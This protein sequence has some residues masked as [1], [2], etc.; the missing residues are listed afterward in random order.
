MLQHLDQVFRWLCQANLKLK[1]AKCCLFRRQ[2]AY[3]GHIVSEDG[4]TTDPSKV[5]KVQNWPVPSSLQEV[6]QFVGLASYYRCFIG[7]FASI[8]KPLHAL[9]KKNARFL[10]TQ[11]YKAA[12]DSL[13]SL[14]TIAPVLGYP[15]DHCEMILDTNASDVGISAV[16]SQAN[17]IL[18]S[19]IALAGCTAMQTAYPGDP[20]A[21]PVYVSCRVPPPIW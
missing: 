11:E 6:R 18:R 19:S 5:R 3:L 12:F 10:W 21:S 20:A 16:L 15:L 14:L 1:L 9:T 2:V 17:L 7:D 8:A 4:V 13:K